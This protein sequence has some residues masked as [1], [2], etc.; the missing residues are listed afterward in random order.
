MT[1]DQLA[2]IGANLIPNERRTIFLLSSF[3]YPPNFFPN[4]ATNFAICSGAIV[5][6][7]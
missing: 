6:P 7:P 3:V 1:V 5:N 2:V 4:Q